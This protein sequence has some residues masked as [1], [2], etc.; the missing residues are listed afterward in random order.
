MSENFHGED[1]TSNLKN[2]N[3]KIISI[4]D[5]A[6][7][8]VVECFNKCFSSESIYIPNSVTTIS[9]NIFEG[10]SSL[11]LIHIPNSVKSLDA[12]FFLTARI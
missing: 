9:H 6:K 2:R 3:I 1:E 10:C 5:G 11:L 12:H 4:P 7:I 8:L